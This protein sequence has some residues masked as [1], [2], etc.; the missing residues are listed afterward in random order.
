MLLL[1]GLEEFGPAPPLEGRKPISTRSPGPAMPVC[2]S[3]SRLEDED[4]E[5]KLPPKEPDRPAEAGLALGAGVV[6]EKVGAPE[7]CGEEDG[8]AVVGRVGTCWMGS[9]LRLAVVGRDDLVGLM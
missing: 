4:L 6:W 9:L 2:R 5:L 7:A 1:K 3:R 8:G